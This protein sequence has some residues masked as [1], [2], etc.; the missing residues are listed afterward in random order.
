MKKLFGTYLNSKNN[1]AA[2]P[3]FH[4]LRI[5]V[6]VVLSLIILLAGCSKQQPE[7]QAKDPIVKADGLTLNTDDEFQNAYKKD[8]Q[9]QDNET[10]A[11]QGFSSHGFSLTTFLELLQARAA[12]AKYRD[13]EKARADS[14][15]DIN[16]VV[17]NMG[18]H[19]M[20]SAIVDAKFEITKPEILVYNKRLDGSFELLAVE[21]AVPISVTPDVAPE[22]FTGS[23]DVWERN[24]VFGLW[25]QHA[26][27]W[28][29]NPDGIF[30]DTNPLV[31]VR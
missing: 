18:Y 1:F 21:Y 10:S 16:V 2:Q 22:G 29:F 13:F 9:S 19:F 6:P 20:K 14:F 11:S 27:I 7:M 15:V 5:G 4:Y 17:P 28:R 24:T 23:A 3:L 25:L 26:W 31:L 12:T 8:I 30:H